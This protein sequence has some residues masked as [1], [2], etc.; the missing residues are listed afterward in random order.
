MTESKKPNHSLS[1]LILHHGIEYIGWVGNLT[2]RHCKIEILL[3]IQF[4][5]VKKKHIIICDY[6]DLL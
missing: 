2:W 4:Y 3:F 1:Y 6:N 5:F